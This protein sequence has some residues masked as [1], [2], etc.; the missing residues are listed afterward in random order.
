MRRSDSLLHD[1]AVRPAGMT[2]AVS[3]KPVRRAGSIGFHFALTRC[4]I[5]AEICFLGGFLWG[6]G[7]G[8]TFCGGGWAG[9]RMSFSGTADG[10]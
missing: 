9:D 1:R 8:C 10:T 4:V 7:G 6:E 5:V 2:S 3:I